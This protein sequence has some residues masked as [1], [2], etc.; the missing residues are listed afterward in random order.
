MDS[1]CSRHDWSISL[2]SLFTSIKQP[3][4]P[5]NIHYCSGSCPISETEHSVLHSQLQAAATDSS[6]PEPCCVPKTYSDVSIVYVDPFTRE[7][8]T[9]DL[10]D[11]VV[12][13]CGCM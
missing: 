9:G 3:V 13:E 6:V 8:V 2:T 10:E 4:E 5:V 11:L 12:D 7:D 1:L